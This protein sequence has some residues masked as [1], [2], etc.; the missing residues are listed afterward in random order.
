MPPRLSEY[1][2]KHRS[3]AST[4]VAFSPDGQE[5]LVNLGGEQIYLFPVNTGIQVNSSRFIMAE[6]SG[7]PSPLSKLILIIG[8][9]NQ[10]ITA[11]KS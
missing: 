4:Y 6:K 9:Q 10:I 7:S 5:L 11:I 2:K 8:S 3:L 1:K